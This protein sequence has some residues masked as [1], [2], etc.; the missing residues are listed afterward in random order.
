MLDDRSLQPECRRPLKNM[1]FEAPHQLD[2]FLS[3][4]HRARPIRVTF[5]VNKSDDCCKILRAIFRDSYHRWGGRRSLIVPATSGT[6]DINYLKWM[7]WYDPDV[8]YTYAALSQET[9]RQI[10]KSC[11]PAVFLRHR[12]TREVNDRYWATPDYHIKPIASVSLIPSMTP[13][14]QPV[15]KLLSCYPGWDEVEII[16]DN[17]GLAGSSNANGLY[18]PITMT[19]PGLGKHMLVSG[20]QVFDEYQLFE[21]LAKD[22]DISSLS[23]YSSLDTSTGVPGFNHQLS[24]ALNLFIGDGF[25]DRLYFWNSRHFSEG[26]TYAHTPSFWLGAKYV[27]DERFVEP[28]VGYLNRWSY[29][30]PNSEGGAVN[31]QSSTVGREVIAAFIAKLRAVKCHRQFFFRETPIEPLPATY[32]E[33]SYYFT[34]Y[35]NNSRINENPCQLVPEEPK[36]FRAIPFQRSYL[37][38]GHCVVDVALERYFNHSRFIN[39]P[40]LWQL[41]RRSGMTRLFSSAM[42]RVNTDHMLS[43][44]YNYVEPALFNTNYAKQQ[45]LEIEFPEDR[46]V[47]SVA[48]SGSTFLPNDDLRNPDSTRREYA[49][50][51]TSDKGR[52]LRAI[53]SIMGDLNTTYHFIANA[54]WR[55]ILEELCSVRKRG[56]N[57]LFSARLKETLQ[58]YF[59]ATLKISDDAGWEELSAKIL[60]ALY[61][62][63]KL[64][65]E[66][67]YEELKG[68]RYASFNKFLGTAQP[69]QGFHKPEARE[70]II[71]DFER[72][73]R[74]LIERKL[75]FQGHQWKCQ[76]CGH[77]NWLSVDSLRLHNECE[78]CNSGQQMPARELKWDLLLNPRVAEALYKD[79]VMPEIWALGQLFDEA[80]CSFYFIPQSEFVGNNDSRRPKFEIDILCVQD[81]QLILGETKTYSSQFTDGVRK[82]LVEMANDL[83]PDRIVIGYLYVDS[84]VAKIVQEFSEE[85]LNVV[86]THPLP[87][88]PV[89]DP[90]SDF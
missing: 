5:L 19:P 54:F 12:S 14:N 68:K 35:G 7:A 13:A 81:G 42:G 32:R 8:V 79:D 41:P 63:P 77:E 65:L 83:S 90:W 62:L 56:D 84:D 69:S 2:R 82:K 53:L 28:F 52:S 73:L 16:A 11:C 57:P 86:T 34:G 55:E 10:D 29:T 3:I 64:K 72:S 66:T 9:I 46:A 37:K 80:K 24:R 51:A 87:E 31:V 20:E 27:I 60:P 22:G 25:E 48:F 45:S 88:T 15:P 67:S 39:A 18:A 89:Y 76:V 30:F 50:F 71:R 1:R 59:G 44:I 40:H 38:E 47:F 33:T 85:G 43:L 58:S 78:V 49:K 6:I 75:F 61:H 26:S 17:F 36:H 70:E 23:F 4:Q 74:R 21:R